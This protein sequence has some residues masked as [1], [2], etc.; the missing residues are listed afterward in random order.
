MEMRMHLC[1]TSGDFTNLNQACGEDL[2]DDYFEIEPGSLHLLEKQLRRQNNGQ[3]RQVGIFSSVAHSFIRPFQSL[4]WFSQQT[5]RRLKQEGLP[6]ALPTYTARRARG[7]PSPA[8]ADAMYLLMCINHKIP[9]SKLHH[10]PIL[11]DQVQADRELF[12]SLRQTYFERRRYLGSLLSVRNVKRLDLVKFVVDLSGV[13]DTNSHSHNTSCG[14]IPD[15]CTC[16]PPPELILPSPTAEYTLKHPP[17]YVP[18]VGSNH[19]THC[20]QHPECIEK[21]EKWIY[22]QVPKRIGSRLE[23]TPESSPLLGWGIGFEEGWD[24]AKLKHGGFLIFVVGS[25]IFAILWSVLKHDIQSAFG[26]SAYWMTGLAVIVGYVAT[27]P[28]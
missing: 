22:N 20:F 13:V 18:A 8:R 4:V 25:F 21:E 15:E 14:T 24:E 26:I 6:S 5:F 2:F 17:K 19:L 9:G 10:Q 27:Y 23:S 28:D 7:P 12:S 1:T 11:R 16:T 3:A